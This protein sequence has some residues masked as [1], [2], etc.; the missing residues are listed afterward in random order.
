MNHCHPLTVLWTFWTDTRQS[1]MY[2]PPPFY[3][4]EMRKAFSVEVLL[5]P[6]LQ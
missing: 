3:K 4:Q 5:S 1:G 6:T 2:S